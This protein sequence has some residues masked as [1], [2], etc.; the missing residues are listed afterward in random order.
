MRRRLLPLGGVVFALGIVVIF[1]SIVVSQHV[2]RL[3][4]APERQIVGGDPG[5]GSQAIMRY[6]CV[7]CHTIAGIREARGRVGPPLTGIAGRSYIAGRI[8]N[9]SENIVLWIQDPQGLIPG[10]AMP[11]LGVTESDA[12]DIAAYLYSLR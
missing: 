9:T 2:H 6:G 3:P 10:T 4:G 1:G 5:E 11:N 7:S 12:R 8:P